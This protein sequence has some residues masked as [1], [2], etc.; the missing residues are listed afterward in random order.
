MGTVVSFSVKAESATTDRDAGAAASGRIDEAR[1]RAKQRTRQ[2]TLRREL[3]HQQEKRYDRQVVDRES[4][5]DDSLEI[6]EQRFTA[7]DDREADGAGHEHR[8]P[9]GQPKR[10]QHEHRGKERKRAPREHQASSSGGAERVL[11]SAISAAS[12]SAGTIGA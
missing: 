8:H 4:C 11:I 1:R 2:A 3:P 12:T 7:C 6:R 9:D 5:K 10:H